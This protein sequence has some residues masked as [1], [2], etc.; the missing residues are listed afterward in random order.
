MKITLHKV[1][2]APHPHPEY[3]LE[4]TGEIPYCVV[5]LSEVDG[6]MEETEM[7]YDTLDEAHKE[8]VLVSSTFDGITL[9]QGDVHDA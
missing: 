4:E 1:L 3:V 9:E 6:V 2:L 7:V 8:A 5:Y